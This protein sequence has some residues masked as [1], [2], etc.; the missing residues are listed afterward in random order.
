[1]A[2]HGGTAQFFFGIHLRGLRFVLQVNQSSM[3]QYREPVCVHVYRRSFLHLW[4]VLMLFSLM[5][6]L[7]K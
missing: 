7:L 4:L 2:R 5:G 6:P 1:M 3:K